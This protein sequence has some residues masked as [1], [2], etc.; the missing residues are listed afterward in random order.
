MSKGGR[1]LVAAPARH[2]AIARQAGIV[3]QSAAQLEGR[4][5]GRILA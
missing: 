1:L 4:L 5:I 2:A 3:K